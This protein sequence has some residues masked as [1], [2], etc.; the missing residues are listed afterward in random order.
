MF[1]SWPYFLGIFAVSVALRGGHSAPLR[2]QPLQTPAAETAEA[3]TAFE[4]LDYYGAHCGRCHG[5]EGANYSPESLQKRDDD[6]L[7]QVIKEM[8]QGPGQAPLEG[9]QLEV[10][11]AWHR[12]FIAGQPFVSVTKIARENDKIQL[13]GEATSDARIALI[14]LTAPD[15]PQVLATREGTNWSAE[16]PANVDLATV[17]VL[18]EQGEIKTLLKFDGELYSHAAAGTK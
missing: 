16:L 1:T 18:A 2:Y 4:A 9:A 10:V 7:Q 14:C 12:A 3:K 6:S 17:Q 11:T 13:R 5:L 15:A 8:A